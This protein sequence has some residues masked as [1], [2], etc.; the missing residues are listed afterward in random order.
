MG[1]VFIA[2]SDASRDF[3]LDVR[4]HLEIARITTWLRDPLLHGEID[5]AL[6]QAA[7]RASSVVL[8]VWRKSSEKTSYVVRLQRELSQARQFNIPIVTLTSEEDLEA[9]I[10]KLKALLPEQRVG[11]PLP[12]P[13]VETDLVGV[14]S[15]VSELQ[16][17]S[18][19]LWLT[20]LITIT[21]ILMSVGAWLLLQS[22][23]AALNPFTVTPSHTPTASQTVTP[24]PTLTLTATATNTATPTRRPTNTVTATL[25]ATHV[26]TQT[27]SSTP[28]PSSIPQHT[29]TTRPSATPVNTSVSEIIN[30]TPITTS[31]SNND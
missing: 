14:E 11:A 20:V 9:V 3:A 13:M 7:L 27:P 2:F 24:S 15:L 6:I 16:R 23:G 22:P 12:I 21:G 1:Y 5:Q 26:P 30:P 10:E 19:R 29:A 18:R 4:N 25:T 31:E 17:P 28:R 8:V